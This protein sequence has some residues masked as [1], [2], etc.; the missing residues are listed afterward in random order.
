MNK[1]SDYLCIFRSK[2]D[3]MRRLDPIGIKELINAMYSFLEG[4]EI[5]PFTDPRAEAIWWTWELEFKASN[6]KRAEIRKRRSEAGFIGGKQN[7]ANASKTKQ[8]EANVSK[9]KQT[10][11][12]E[13]EKTFASIVQ[14]NVSKPKQTEANENGKIFA[15]SVQAKSSYTDTDTDT[16]TDNEER[17]NIKRDFSEEE[18]LELA[19]LPDICLSE[20]EARKFYCHYAQQNWL[21]A[22]GQRITNLALALRSWKMKK[23]MFDTPQYNHSE[24]SKEEFE[25]YLREKYRDALIQPIEYSQT[26]RD[27]E[28]MLSMSI[29]EQRQT[30]EWKEYQA[31]KNRK[32]TL[33]NRIYAKFQR[34]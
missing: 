13:N 11:A 32:Y 5:Q 29:D 9:M 31:D 33:A 3:V 28:E 17:E 16:D 30:F 24:T 20:D 18:V 26:R 12:N 2:F 15:S 25:S 7:Q 4:E 1:D 10:E 22:N 34:N 8:N 6:K 27:V 19:K 21:R 23:G 14:A